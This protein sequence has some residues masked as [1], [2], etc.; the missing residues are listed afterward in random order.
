MEYGVEDELQV[1]FEL[2]DSVSGSFATLGGEL[3]DDGEVRRQALDLVGDAG[4]RHV[5][6][7]DLQL[8]PVDGVH[9]RLSAVAAG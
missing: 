7:T 9:Q 2:V 5:Q 3:S 8:D 1:P 6:T 4:V